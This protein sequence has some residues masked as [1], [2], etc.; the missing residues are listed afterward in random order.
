M[1]K[2]KQ[3]NK[4]NLT[5]RERFER[6]TQKGVSRG[7]KR[8]IKT[9]KQWKIIL[10]TMFSVVM[11]VFVMKSFQ[12]N[13]IGIPSLVCQLLVFSGIFAAIFF[14][15]R[16]MSSTYKETKI[17]YGDKVAWW[18]VRTRRGYTRW[19]RLLPKRN[20]GI[21]P[22]VLACFMAG[23]GTILGL[24]FIVALRRSLI[25][26]TDNQ[27]PF[28]QKLASFFLPAFVAFSPVMFIYVFFRLRK[29]NRTVRHLR[30]AVVI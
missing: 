25:V 4:S 22:I 24:L 7:A 13:E 5:F 15:L 19:G 8:A 20:K 3:T 23:F 17:L 6:N 30:E 9:S 28:W 26:L 2:K 27:L 11:V 21:P 10:W 1:A 18:T 29:E 16:W 12:A 14:I